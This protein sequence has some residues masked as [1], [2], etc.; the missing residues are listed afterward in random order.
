MKVLEQTREVLVV[1]FGDALWPVFAAAGTFIIGVGVLVGGSVARS[2]PA[3]LIGM[4]LVVLGGLL[5]LREHHVTLTFN[6]TTRMVHARRWKNLMPGEALFRLSEI[7]SFDIACTE[8]RSR[9]MQIVL[10]RSVRCMIIAN[11]PTGP[12]IIL[13]RGLTAG[14]AA[15]AHRL[16]LM[17]VE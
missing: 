13:V 9:L 15:E 1:R 10:M 6:R 16:I 2:L 14:E 7:T 4:L 11:F 5:M 17:Y 8:K 12:D 3:S